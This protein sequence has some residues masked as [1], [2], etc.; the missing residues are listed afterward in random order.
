MMGNPIEEDY[1]AVCPKCLQ[2][3]VDGNHLCEVALG[4]K[5]KQIEE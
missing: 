1:E 2:K 3:R 5:V 4:Q